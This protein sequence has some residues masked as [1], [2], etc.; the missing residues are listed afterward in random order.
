MNEQKNSYTT[1][2]RCYF[3]HFLRMRDN[4]HRLPIEIK[5]PRRYRTQRNI[6]IPFVALSVFSQGYVASVRSFNPEYITTTNI[7]SN[8]HVVPTT[9]HQQLFVSPITTSTE[10]TDVVG[11]A[12]KNNG[13]STSTV[14]GTIQILMSDTGGGHRASAIALQDAF[15]T[16]YPPPPSSSTSSS[17]TSSSSSTKTKIQCDIVDIYTE[18]GPIWPYNNYIS[19]Y[20]YMAAHPWMWKLLY[21]FG[22]SDFGLWFNQ[23]M[24][25]LFCTE[26]FT[27]CISRIPPISDNGLPGHSPQRRADMI[28]SVHPLTQ[29][30]P[31]KILSQLDNQENG[32]R[33]TPFVTVVTDLGS[34]H[35]TWFNPGYVC[36]LQ[37]YCFSQILL[38]FC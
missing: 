34:A 2:K 8:A 6:C 3:I 12:H 20:K 32:Q 33:T 7:R 9:R 37:L 21:E 11:Q 38:S 25:E 14:V 4:S 35:P 30:L 15:N 1:R 26:A 28:I 22:Q 36:A 5:L 16:L 17:S 10:N 23:F 18:Y 19:I 24:L 13:D 31:L 27:K 29:D